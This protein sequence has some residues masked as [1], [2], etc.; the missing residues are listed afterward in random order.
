MLVTLLTFQFPIFALKEVQDTNMFSILV[1]PLTFQL[2][3]FVVVLP[4]LVQVPN[5]KPIL[6]S[7]PKYG[8]SVALTPVKLPH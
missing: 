8:L 7:V 6:I 5:I 1:I 2:F 4:K 3:I